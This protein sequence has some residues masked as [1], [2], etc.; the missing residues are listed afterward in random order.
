MAALVQTIPQQSSAVPVLQ[1]RPSSSSGTF[2]PSQSL[3][4]SNSHN[5][6]MS[7]NTYNT[8]GNPGP[9]RP[10]HQVVAPYA[11]TSTPSLSDSPNVQKN[12]QSWSPSLRPEHRTSSAPSAPQLPANAAH[13]GVNSRPVHHTAAGSV[14]TSSP[15]PSAPSYMSKD[16][17]AIPSR[18]LHSDPPMRPL[19]TANLPSPASLL[20]MSSPTV[21]RP[22]PD[23]YRRGNRRSDVPGGARASP[24]V[25]D[26]NLQ[27]TIASGPAAARNLLPD[28]KSQNTTGH[29]RVSSAD[30]ASRQ[31]KPHPEL[32]KRYRRRSWGNM[33]NTGLINLEL[34][35][36]AASPI[37]MPK[38]QDY[39][40]QER[41]RS[42]QSARDV[43][44]S[45]SSARSSSSSV[46]E[47]TTR[48]GVL[49]TT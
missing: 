19:S 7:W 12:R 25:M 32:A 46:R 43:S 41:P 44:G 39:F 6:A 5:P 2:T 47:R 30:D 35:L 40:D 31:E 21:A 26:E 23:R 10:G 14:S 29:A 42:A 49:L 18:H 3:Q 34:K 15:K 4:Q 33:D 22:S 1:N 28:S 11:F 37:P 9:Y 36:P 17:S 20:N 48:Y 24:P 27:Q 8:A 38:G 45:N 13:A 16:D